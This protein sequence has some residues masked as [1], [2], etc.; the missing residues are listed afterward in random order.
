MKT[1]KLTDKQQAFAANKAAGLK[2]RD[3]AIA[4]GFAPNNADVQAAALLR[5]ADIKA[6]IEAAKKQKKPAGV[7][8][9]DTMSKNH[10]G[11]SMEFL[12]D[13]MNH[14]HLPFAL[15]FDAAKALLPYQHARIG[16]QGK[17][18]KAKERAEVLSRKPRFSPS[19]PP[20]ILRA[21]EGGKGK[22]DE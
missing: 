17:K 1:T 5:R 6:A 7:T 13:A 18:E 19:P 4:A 22:H 16:E 10:Y 12:M 8:K 3:A 9:T 21:I 15:R 14:A 20:R 2:N 11:D